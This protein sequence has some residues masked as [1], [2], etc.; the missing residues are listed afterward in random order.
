MKVCHICAVDFTLNHFLL[1]LIDRMKN[2]GWDVYA[3]CSR[4][5]NS[6]DLKDKGYNLIN[7]DIPRNLNPILIIKT[8]IS[9]YKEFKKNKFD[10]IHVHTPVASVVGRI[11]AKLAGVPLVIYTAHGFYF[12][13]NMSIFKFYIYLYIEKF[14]AYFTDLIF[15]QSI[16]Y[17]NISK[18]HNFLDD[19]KLFHIGN[20]VDSTIF[21][22]KSIIDMSKTKKKL[23][24]PDNSFVIGS[25]CRLVEEK[26]ILE[27]LDAAE[28]I[29]KIY[30]DVYFLLIGSRL[31]TEH[32]TN[33]NKQIFSKKKKLGDKLLLLGHRNDIPELLSILDIFCLPSWR[34]GLSRSIIEAMFMAKPIITTNIR[35][36]REQVDH[37]KNGLIIPIKSSKKIFNSVKF[38]INDPDT[39]KKFG[40]NARK[41]AIKFYD[42]KNVLSFQIKII[43]EKIHNVSYIKK[44]S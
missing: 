41:K 3:I 12:H 10:I 1:P 19:D 34:E 44:S 31:D 36:C 29:S 20:G 35:G 23:G 16:E 28:M 26:G 17:Y 43:K 27:F 7:V 33:I 2:E 13:E 37:K 11:A 30:P 40:K 22:P 4:G 24:I 25:I 14:F 32:N 15:F 8:I 18:K 5:S 21:I 39:R 38:L 42:E 9:L 6:K